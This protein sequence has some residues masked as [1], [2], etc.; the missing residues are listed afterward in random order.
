MLVVYWVSPIDLEFYRVRQ[1]EL[2]RDS[3]KEQERIW[4]ATNTVTIENDI[5]LN[6][7]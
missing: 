3:T 4:N 6:S 5:F 1:G 2:L 7:I